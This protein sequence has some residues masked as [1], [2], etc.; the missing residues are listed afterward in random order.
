MPASDPQ[1]PFDQADAAIAH[2]QSL[3]AEAG[4]ADPVD[5][6]LRTRLRRDLVVALRLR[7]RW[8]YWDRRPYAADSPTVV[9]VY[10]L[11][12]ATQ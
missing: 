5:S 12:E 10:E 2:L 3:L 4:R 7:E 11:M 6:G 1:R 8:G 9:S